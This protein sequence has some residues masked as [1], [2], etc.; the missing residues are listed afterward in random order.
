MIQYDDG[1][2]LPPLWHW[3]YF[4][5]LS[6]ES[7]NYDG[8]AALGGF[9]TSKTATPHVG[10]GRVSFLNDFVIR[11]KARKVSTSKSIQ[12]KSSKSGD[13]VFVTVA[14]QVFQHEACCIE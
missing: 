2:S 13:L 6:T 7:G 8:H 1:S 12:Q 3:L 10:G 11:A 4:T 5:D 9:A 14:H